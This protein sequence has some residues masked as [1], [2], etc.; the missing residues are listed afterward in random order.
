MA[1]R[2]AE[3]D[4]FI[5]QLGK[6]CPELGAYQVAELGRKLLRAGATLQRLTEAQCNGDWPYDC[7]REYRDVADFAQCARCER[8]TRTATLNKVKLCP[9]CRTEDR[10]TAVAAAHGL[11]IITQ[12]DPRGYVLRVV[13]AD[14]WQSDQYGHP[15]SHAPGVI[16]VP[17]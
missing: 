1:G 11:R 16:G 3:R 8:D 4:Q 12:G 6:A 7:G 14:Q 13:R 15:D 10:I 5:A 2:Q 17:A 9:D